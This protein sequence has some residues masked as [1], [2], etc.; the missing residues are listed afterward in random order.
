VPAEFDFL[1]ID[2]DRNDYWIWRAIEHYTPRVVAVEYNASFKASVACTVPYAPDAA[3]DG[4]SN[5]YGCSLKA[6][7]HLADEK[8][9]CLVGCNYTGVTAFF[10]R[11]DCVE[12]RF[13]DPYTSENH[14]ERPRYFTRMPNGHAPAFGPVEMVP[15][16]D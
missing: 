9:Y 16:K 14:Y 8:G 2:I 1:S 4:Y 13:L 5:Y 10:V 3:W 6:L 12:D 11:S 7:Q 15:G